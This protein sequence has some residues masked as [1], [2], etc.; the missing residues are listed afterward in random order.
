MASTRYPPYAT[1]LYN[2]EQC[3]HPAIEEWEVCSPTVG[4][5][6]EYGRN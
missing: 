6:Y 5:L 4:E 3:V 1:S 2:E